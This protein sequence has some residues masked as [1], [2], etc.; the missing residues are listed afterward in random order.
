M[1]VYFCAYRVGLG[2]TSCAIS[3]VKARHRVKMI[4]E[5]TSHVFVAMGL[6][7]SYALLY[8]HTEQLYF[9]KM[10]I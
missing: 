8:T 10:T 6:N 9:V 2:S 7:S 5:I 1:S 4:N 3:L